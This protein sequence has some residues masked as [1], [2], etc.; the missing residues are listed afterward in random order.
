[1]WKILF[2]RSENTTLLVLALAVGLATGIGVWLFR[3]GIELFHTFF[4][5][6]LAVDLLGGLLGKWA[7]VPVLA[8]AGFVVGWLMQRFVGQERYHGLA[9]VIES[10]ALS[11]G[12]LRYAVMPIKAISS[13]LSLGAGASVG[14]EAPSVVIGANIGS[15][16]GQRLRLSEERSRLLV[17]AG[18]A[19]AIAAA[20]RAPIAGVFFALEV[21]M[22]GEFTTGSFG[23][24]VL[25]AVISSAFVQAIE[26][27]APEF[28]QLSFTLGN[29]L[30]LVLYVLLGL[31]L[32]P[33]S[34]LF[35]H[36]VGW[37]HN[38]WH[39]IHL[40]QP[41]KTALAGALVGIV[42]V[43]LP[44]ILGTGRETIGA[45]LS[46]E[47]FAFGFLLALG[48][49][50]LMT[51]ALSI[52]GGFVG[53]IFAPTLFVGT[54]LGAAYGQLVSYFIPSITDH[55]TY[56]VAGMAAV[57][58]GVVRA[59]ITGILLVFELTND[60]RLILP[61]M[62][63]T[64]V[65]V[66]LT[67][68][69]VPAGIDVLSLL[70]AGLR[71]EQGRDVDVMQGI[72]VGEAMVTPPP[73]IS[74]EASLADLR[75]ALREQSTRALCV[76]DARERLTG[77]VTMVDL[78]LA[79]EANQETPPNVG[80]MCSKDVV[81]VSPNDPLWV[82]IRSMGARGIAQLPV[83]DERTKTLVGL[84]KRSGV[85]QAYQTAIARKLKTQHHAEQIRLKNLTGAHVFE[86]HIDS[87]AMIV[88]KL[89]RDIQWP[90][91]SVIASIRRDNKL[92]VPHGNTTLHAQDTLT[93][94]AEAG[95]EDQLAMLCGYEAS[96][97]AVQE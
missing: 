31:L 36:L 11:G 3:A 57:M 17:A 54:A 73:T 32:A 60:Y 5:E 79:Y 43:F 39:H 85:M 89:I 72:T 61:I 9:G 69:M 26:G 82:A 41:V 81:S 90:Q 92:I 27:G 14:P 84:V 96:A 93:V 71:L 25:A 49:F 40:S 42:G 4:A 76:V 83:L 8:L 75:R 47:H 56:A 74:E 91:E 6:K 44:Q 28:G 12:R 19:S 16:F 77:I 48:A 95:A 68:R 62:L 53:G 51:S 22:N 97:P 35:I 65:C 15:F 58:A 24:V 70:K 30:E 34:V 10:V 2:R 55:Q 33:L 1:M 18:S 64:V 50:K 45:I 21:I 38:V 46:G 13:A 52:A 67:E 20:F 94:V 66:Y 7:I 88:G 78:Q 59:P 23:V 87:G 80:A 29:P 86:L 63:T 37:Q